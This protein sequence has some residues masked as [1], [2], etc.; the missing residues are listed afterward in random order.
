MEHGHSINGKVFR[1]EQEGHGK[2]TWWYRGCCDRRTEATNTNNKQH[3]TIE[4]INSEL[5]TSLTRVF[6]SLLARFEAK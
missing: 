1:P 2:Q 5:V 4:L 6:Q 3:T